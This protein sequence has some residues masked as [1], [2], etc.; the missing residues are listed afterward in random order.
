MKRSSLLLT[1]G[2]GA[3][4]LALSAGA[5][6]SQEEA[7][8]RQRVEL[9]EQQLGEARAQVDGLT[10]AL[11][12]NTQSL[13]QLTRWVEAQ[14][15]SAAALASTLDSAE[16]QGFTAGINFE[17]RETLLAGWRKALAETQKGLASEQPK[18]GAVAKKR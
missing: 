10:D 9:L 16:A 14:S 8:L 2:L 5:Q 12:Q 3:V 15:K 17:S 4:V 1:L 18:A 6:S 13:D 11:T 7:D